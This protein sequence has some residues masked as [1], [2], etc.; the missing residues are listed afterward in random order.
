MKKLSERIAKIERSYAAKCEALDEYYGQT[1]PNCDV[2]DLDL[3]SRKTYIDE[4]D[5]IYEEEK[6]AIKQEKLK[7][8]LVASAI[9][10]GILSLAILSLFFI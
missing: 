9:T 7:T 6:K 10:L 2:R 8:F 5:R 3:S 4:K 1:G